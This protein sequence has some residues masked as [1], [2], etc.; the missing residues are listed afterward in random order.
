MDR[1]EFTGAMLALFGGV[2]L[3]APVREQL[4]YTPF[5]LAK[6]YPSVPLVT[7]RMSACKY[8][9]TDDIFKSFEGADLGIPEGTPVVLDV[10]AKPVPAPRG[11][12]RVFGYV[13][14]PK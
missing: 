8:I 11:A 12:E 9:L 4:I 1:R 14:K 10:N 2:V 3:P 5:E 7:V 6:I 13:V